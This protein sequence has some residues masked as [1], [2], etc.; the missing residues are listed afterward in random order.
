MDK[1]LKAF[2]PRLTPARRQEQLCFAMFR[3]VTYLLIAAVTMIFAVI[4]WK[5]GR[6]LVRGG[7]NWE[8]LA[9]SPETLHVFSDHGTE[10]RM[11][12]SEFR[13]FL[14]G[15][16]EEDLQNHQTYSYAAGGIFPC[17]VGTV[18]LV[19]GS[20]VLALT[21]GVVAAVY[22][23]EY[24]RRGRFIQ[25]IRLS[26][27]NLA[28]VPSIVFG[29]FG[30]AA[31]TLYGPVVVEKVQEKSI[32][33][34]PLLVNGMFLSFEG[35]G[36]SLLAGWF[37]LAF[38]VLP[39]IITASEESLRAVPNGYREGAL[40]LGATKWQS[41][42]TNVLPY[43]LPG[44][45]TSSVLGIT[46]VAG[47]TAP[48]MFTAAFVTRNTMPWEVGSLGEFLLSGVQ[49]LPYHIYVISSKVPQ[50]EHTERVQYAT[51]FVFLIIVFFI[52]LASII[53]R[54]KVREKIRW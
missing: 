43:A 35:W 12:D 2:T 1:P 28:G 45:L 52:A 36:V 17:I 44:I 49:A 26:I 24:S 4:L 48:I 50:N 41:I 54:I 40:A 33:A 20:I 38:M 16:K 23:S 34:V 39:I 21:L 13:G 3:G 32:L 14:A 53:L 9:R 6:E 7:F 29:L 47:E 27:I 25:L 22:L 46:R 18:L 10:H 30:F 42:R 15:K 19:V 31:F 51:A 8:F 5:G 11:G 37:T